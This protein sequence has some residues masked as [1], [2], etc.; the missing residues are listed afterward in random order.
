MFPSQVEGFV[1]FCVWNR[2]LSWFDCCA[3]RVLLSFVLGSALFLLHVFLTGVDIHRYGLIGLFET[4]ALY[5]ADEVWW[6][7]ERHSLRSF[8]D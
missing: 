4:V 6:R 7:S 5:S 3:R 2:G 8:T 1:L